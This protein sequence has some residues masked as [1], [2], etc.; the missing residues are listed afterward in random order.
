MLP[1]PSVAF[2]C[3]P[4]RGSCAAADGQ[5]SPTDCQQGSWSYATPH[6][7]KVLQ[8]CRPGFDCENL[9]IANCK[10]VLSTQKLEHSTCITLSILTV[11][12]VRL[13]VRSFVTET[14]AACAR[15][16]MYFDL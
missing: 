13:Y 6:G 14:E 4:K 11:G 3:C 12:C 7:T 9:I 2:L 5:R 8:G 15:S 16:R 10:F 1:G